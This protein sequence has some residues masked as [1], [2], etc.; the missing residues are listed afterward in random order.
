MTPPGVVACSTLY[1]EVQARRPEADVRYV[2]QEYHEFPVSDP[3]DDEIRGRVG[4]AVD[5]LDTPDRNRIVLL[6]ATTSDGL[7]GVRTEHATLVVSTAGDCIT[8]FLGG[9]DAPAPDDDD[10][11]APGDGHA[12]S[13]DDGDAPAPNDGDA[14]TFGTYYLTRGWVDAAVDAYKL[15][16]AYRGEERDLVDWFERAGGDRW[17]TWA[18]GERYRQAVEQGREM[19]AGT[20]D[21]FFHE[22]VQYYDRVVLLDTGHLHE[23][24]RE[25]ADRFRGFVEDLRGEHGDGG[26]V[27]LEVVDADPTVLEELLGDEPAVSTFADVYEPGNPVE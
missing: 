18:D 22:V 25:Y 10:A 8:T 3:L 12:P 2:P 4:A 21:R 20:V 24:D 15:Y 14:K 19:D 5:D 7:V 16:R 1:P 13:P 27:A 11:P 6:Y 26:S 9:G 17:V 23:F